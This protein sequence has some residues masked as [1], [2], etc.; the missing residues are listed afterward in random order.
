MS[1]KL[2]LKETKSAIIENMEIINKDYKVS[3]FEFVKNKDNWSLI[4]SFLKG[5][6]FEIGDSKDTGLF[7]NNNALLNHLFWIDFKKIYKEKINSYYKD[8]GKNAT[9]ESLNYDSPFY[10][11]NK[12]KPDEADYRFHEIYDN[13]YMRFIIRLKNGNMHIE[14][15]PLFENGYESLSTDKIEPLSNKLKDL[16]TC[17]SIKKMPVS[18]E[19]IGVFL[20][21]F[22]FDTEK[23]FVISEK[24][25]YKMIRDLS[26]VKYD[27]ANFMLSQNFSEKFL[28]DAYVKNNKQ[29]IDKNTKIKI[30]F[31]R[32]QNYINCLGKDIVME[33]SGNIGVKQNYHSNELIFKFCGA[34]LA[35]YSI[36]I[37]NDNIRLIKDD[38]ILT[39]F[40]IKE[41]SVRDLIVDNIRT[42]ISKVLKKERTH[43][44]IEKCLCS[45]KK[46]FKDMNIEVKNVSFSEI[47]VEDFTF[48]NVP[49]LISHKDEVLKTILNVSENHNFEKNPQLNSFK[50]KIKIKA[51]L[52]DDSFKNN[53][54]M[55]KRI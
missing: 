16:F 20:D 33:L 23:T 28:I 22:L 2:T 21:K 5:K 25:I 40:D 12:K 55:K 11:N 47:E 46:F 9:T 34:H 38:K 24:Q 7:R 18:R 30:I 42:D 51:L 49:F 43:E 1:K 45:L 53:L 32:E 52:E 37:K 4:E 35:D 19:N 50:E 31:D 15:K 44:S 14:T 39:S 29:V 54:M 6:G 10:I 13:V 41:G 27:T 17:S 3:H 8:I 48:H 26:P 36:E